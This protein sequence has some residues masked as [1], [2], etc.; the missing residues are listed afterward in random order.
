MCALAKKKDL[1]KYID[2]TVEAYKEYSEA[3]F[4]GRGSPSEFNYG[5]SLCSACRC[6]GKGSRIFDFLEVIN[7]WSQNE[8]NIEACVRILSFWFTHY[9]YQN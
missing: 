5:H 2:L 7:E 1:Y 9:M 3:L 8:R 4:F 6:E